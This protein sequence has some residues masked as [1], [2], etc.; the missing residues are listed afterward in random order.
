MTRTSADALARDVVPRLLAAPT[1][2][3]LDVLPPLQPQ[4]RFLEVG[5]AGGLVARALVERIAGLGWL[6]A[7][8]VDPTHV[9]ALPAVPRRAARAVAALPLPLADGAFDVALANL[10]LGGEDDARWWPELR[11]VLKPGGALLCTMFVRGSWDTLVDLVAEAGEVAGFDAVAD[12]VLR[13]RDALPT[14]HAL[15][16]AARAHGFAPALPT[17]LEERL[18]G[19]AEDGAAL[20]GDPIV[21]DVLLPRLLDGSAHDPRA[22]D[23]AVDDVV[24]A[25]FPGGVPVVA[26]TAVLSLRAT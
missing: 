7:V 22:L 1:E 19:F 13:A 26:R 6:V 14:E 9:A 20:R 11:R 8:D 15:L 4:T 24:H 10:V 5:A 25:Y 18:V 17:G 3:L 21:R 2:L 23:D 16:D 12:A